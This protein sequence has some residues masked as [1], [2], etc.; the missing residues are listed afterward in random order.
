[1]TAFQIVNTVSGDELG[2]YYAD[3][4]ADALDALARYAGYPDVAAARAAMPSM[5]REVMLVEL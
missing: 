2:R 5:E 1:M 4:P 3:K